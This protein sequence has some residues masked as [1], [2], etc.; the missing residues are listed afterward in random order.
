VNTINNTADVAVARRPGKL[1]FVLVCVFLDM[2]GVGI[3]LPSLPIFIGELAGSRATQAYWYG[4][5][6]MVYGITTFLFSPILGGLSDRFGRRPVLL[7]SMLGMALNFIV[8]ASAT[9][10]TGLFI[11]RVIGGLSS[12]NMSVASAYAT[13]VSE[14]DERAKSFG[15]IGAA[16][17]IGFIFGPLL[18]GLLG[19]TSLH[20][21]FYVAAGLCLINAVYGY[22]FVVESLAPQKRHPFSLAKANAFSALGRLATSPATRLLF[23]AFG[24]QVMAGLMSQTTFALYTN[25]RF[26]WSPFEVGAALCCVGVGSTVMQAFLLDRLVKWLGETRLVLIGQ[27]SGGLAFLLYGVATQGWMIYVVI[28]FNIFSFASPAALQSIVSKANRSSGHGTLMG[29]MQSL[30]SLALV[31]APL[32]GSAIL[33]TGSKLPASDWRMGS[34]YY[35][36][37]ALQLGALL[38]MWCYLRSRPVEAAA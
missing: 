23:I 20:L 7:L 32:L 22:F 24:L 21:P 30:R 2:L 10:L 26:G 33:A 25:F 15:R 36:C 5:L 13:D 6:V 17:S 29:S 3:V 38:V 14:P 28:L 4:M 37:A 8:T 34:V 9:S 35:V 11:G 19:G 31:L 1:N 12:A 18:G 16:F 27:T